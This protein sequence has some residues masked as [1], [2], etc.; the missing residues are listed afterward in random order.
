[1][2]RIHEQKRFVGLFIKKQKIWLLRDS[3]GHYHTV[4]ST[5]LQLLQI[6]NSPWKLFIDCTLYWKVP[7]IC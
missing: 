3:Q 4:W 2:H 1:M 6:V 5:V 7:I